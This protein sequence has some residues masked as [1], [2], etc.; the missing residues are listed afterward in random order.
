MRLLRS[1]LAGCVAALLIWAAPTSA[2]AASPAVRVFLDD[3]QSSALTAL[4]LNEALYFPLRALAVSLR[5]TLTV[6]GVELEVRRADGRVFMVRVGRRE[7][8]ADAQVIALAESPVLLVNG[9]TMAPRGAVETMFDALVIWN[10][11]ENTATLV[12]QAA[13]HPAEPVPAPIR[14]SV[15]PI[16]KTVT[17]F[18]PEFQPVRERPVVAS[19]T[20]GVTLSASGSA[21]SVSSHLA[22][23]SQGESGTIRGAF[24]IGSGANGPAGAEGI[25]TWRRGSSLLSAGVLSIYDS[26]LTL[27]EQGFVGLMYDQR[28][29]SIQTRFFG[30]M[31]PGSGGSVYGMSIRLPQV[32]SLLAEATLLYS[33][34]ANATIA[35]GRVDWRLRPGVSLFGEVAVGTSA[36]GSG[37]GWR[38]GVEYASDRWTISLS[39]L[40]LGPRF[41]TLGNAAVFAGRHGPVIELAYHPNSRW[42]VLASAALLAGEPGIPSRLAYRV[43]LQYQ[44]SA[45]LAVVG[46][47]RST[48][49]PVNGVRVRRDSAQVSLLYTSGR[50][51]AALTAGKGL[52]EQAGRT[53]ANSASVSLRA[54]YVLSNGWPVWGEASALIGDTRGWVLSAGTRFK[55]NSRFDLT[56]QLRS[57]TIVWPSPSAERAVELGIVHPLASGGQ[58][59]VGAG[60]KLTSSSAAAPYLTIGYTR[61]F[62]VFGPLRVGQVAADVF[63]DSNGNGRRD[64]GEP[65]VAGVVIRLDARSAARTDAAGHSTVEGVREGEYGVSVDENTVPVGLVAQQPET[66]VRI[67]ADGRTTIS[68]GLI[69]AA[70]LRCVVY[71]DENGNGVREKTEH[72]ISDV[73]VL[74]QPLG[75]RIISDADG[76]LVFGDLRSGAYTAVIDASVLPAGLKMGGPGTFTTTLAAGGSASCEL[77]VLNAKP[78]VVTFP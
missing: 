78:I 7:I 23:V 12:T 3:A 73:S 39:Y 65:G 58:L 52:D 47:A 42:L 69:P 16:A 6:K 61:P 53:T 56:A 54:G 55:V 31:L 4:I 13:F 22:F 26:P 64:P 70:A 10:K 57:K 2:A 46:E 28:L 48:D 59:S 77:P 66:R 21:L 30:G 51:N 34:E 14:A 72:G 20:V 19:G 15:R 5:A 35:R 41:P 75:R 25:L 63:I 45:S 44:I 36:A 1:A 37:L 29:G 33:P 68:F 62:T 17:T 60:V 43:F 27:Y 18:A 24:G 71:L 49:E 9:I 32:G 67:T 8:W 50:W 38:S 40:S 74:L 76:V 11:E